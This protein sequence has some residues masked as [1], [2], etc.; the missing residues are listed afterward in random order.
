MNESRKWKDKAKEYRAFARYFSESGMVGA[1]HDARKDAAYCQ[2]K[3]ARAVRN[4]AVDYGAQW[5]LLDEM[6]GR[7][8]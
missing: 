5:V 8:A 6:D 4:P 3:A 1:A 7:T 2:R